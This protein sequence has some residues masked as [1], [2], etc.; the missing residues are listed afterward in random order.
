[1][2]TEIKI[3]RIF[4]KDASFESQGP[5]KVS[6]W[7][8]HLDVELNTRSEK[9]KDENDA[10]K[11]AYEVTLR[12]MITAKHQEQHAFTVQVQQSGVF[13]VFASS[14]EQKKAILHVQCPNILF[15]FVRE[16]VATLVSKGGFPQLLLGP[17]SFESIY[18]QKNEAIK[19]QES[20]TVTH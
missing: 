13:S 2:A 6:E 12:A 20:I 19:E 10:Y 17:M 1:M 4:L 16:T 15:P 3:H 5:K 8:P 9:I 7:K 14:L 11:D 18:R